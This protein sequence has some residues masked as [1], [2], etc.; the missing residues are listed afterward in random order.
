MYA[1]ISGFNEIQTSELGKSFRFS[2]FCLFILL[3]GANVY[4]Q[5]VDGVKYVLEQMEF[6]QGNNS[7]EKTLG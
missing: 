6:S 3:V 5:E 2:N 7:L 1:N 4:H